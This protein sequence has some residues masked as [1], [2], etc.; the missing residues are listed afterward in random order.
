MSAPAIRPVLRPTGE[1]QPAV[2][3]VHSGGGPP[4]SGRRAPRIAN[5]V[6]AMVVFLGTET[7]LFAALISAY[8]ILRAGVVLWPPADQPRLPVLITGLNTLVLLCSAYTMSRAA[9]ASR[10]RQQAAVRQWLA[11]TGALGAT[12]L[13]VQGVEWMRL[14]RHGLGVSTSLYGATFYTVIGFHAVHVAAAVLTLL[15]LGL[16]LRRNADPEATQNRVA[17]AALYW[18]FVVAVWPVLYTLV[19]LA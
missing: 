17:A 4:A 10:K 1:V 7:M 5:G 11:I 9:A 2:R 14:L 18:L 8:L 15:A 16:W 3:L 12:F 19:Y 13:L 6:L